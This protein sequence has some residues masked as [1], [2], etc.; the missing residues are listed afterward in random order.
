MNNTKL[1]FFEFSELYQIFNELNNFFNYELKNI[2]NMKDLEIELKNTKNYL[3]LSNNSKFKFNN[4]V[5]LKELLLRVNKILEKINIAIL[6]NNFLKKSNIK[7]GKYRINLNSR[8]I[9]L[10][11]KSLKLTEK[12]IRIIFYLSESI[13]PVNINELQKNIWGYS[14]ELETHTVETH[15]HRL[16]KKI[17]NIYKDKNFILSTKNGYK[18]A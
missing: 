5:V 14:S 15:I 13:N 6:K 3:I 18:I 9:F 4:K 1:I 17:L 10:Q 11:K 8:E 12:E 7:I 2:N 16:R